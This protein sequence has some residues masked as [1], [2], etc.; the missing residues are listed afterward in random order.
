VTGA[1]GAQIEAD[2]GEGPAGPGDVGLAGLL[3]LADGFADAE[4]RSGLGAFLAYLE[5]GEQLGAEEAV[6]L[7]PT[8]GSVQLMTMHKAK[9][10]EFDVVVL[11]HLCRD[12]FPGGVGSPR[13]TTRPLVVPSELR[14][15]RHVLPA[16][17]EFTSA[18]LKEFVEDCHAHDRGGDDRL[19]YVGVTRAREVIIA[20]GH[21]WGPTQK[22]PRGP[23]PYL[24]ALREEALGAPDPGTADPGSTQLGAT[25]ADDQ[26]PGSAPD[27]WVDDPG[28]LAD[29]VTDNPMLAV[30]SEV[31]WPV[32]DP[33]AGE[34]AAMAAA[35]VEALLAAGQV[36]ALAWP[37]P[38]PPPGP[39]SEAGR[40]DAPAA[41][42]SAVANP[43]PDPVVEQW[44]AAIAAL[45]ARMPDAGAGLGPGVR[46]PDV[47]TT[48]AA[49]DLAADPRAFAE[50]L[51]RPM[52]RPRNRFADLGTA[53]HAWVESRLG[54]QP[55]IPDDELPGAAD[56]AISSDEELAALKA[57]FELL[58][59]AHR[60]PTGLE[61]PFS[62]QIGGRLVRGRI[63]AVFPAAPGAP[64][65]QQWEVIDWK[66]SAADVADPLQL[67]I[68]RLAWAQ[69]VGVEPDAVGA[70]FAFVRSGRIVT[71]EVLPGAAELAALI[72]SGAPA[73]QAG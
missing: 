8:P 26:A 73:G 68:Y 3:Q 16:L 14:D 25:A 4:G 48:S 18:A 70:S 19:A 5:A 51:L 24:E 53:F 58:P 1:L 37:D 72:L 45:L 32:P 55:L 54:V 65:G 6:D 62:I 29:E 63:D 44:D 36:P 50:R 23:S 21:W 61:V 57:A 69:R 40:S 22:R 17:S 28:G 20:S 7:P 64:P 38:S 34:P 10:L 49:T 66:T 42:G 39:T 30:G 11:P 41:D 60:R 13:W 52:P 71:P 31:P 56:E 67:A 33:A 59:H 2:L 35:A 47:L 27:P 15:D 9:G 12:V 46:V 43:A